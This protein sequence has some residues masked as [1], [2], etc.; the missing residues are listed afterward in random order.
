MKNRLLG[1]V[2]AGATMLTAGCNKE[3]DKIETFHYF[4]SDGNGLYDRFEGRT[5]DKK[6]NV[7]HRFGPYPIE[8]HPYKEVPNAIS[9]PH[10]REYMI[11]DHKGQKLVLH[12]YDGIIEEH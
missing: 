6:G 10:D 2:L 12:N 3:N 11:L 7:V 5:L 1:I 4:D 9:F 8:E